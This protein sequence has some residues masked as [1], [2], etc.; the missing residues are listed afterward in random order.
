[1]KAIWKA[2]NNHKK[3]GVSRYLELEKKMERRERW[4]FFY[5]EN[6]AF[7][8]KHSQE[9]RCHNLDV[10]CLI[11]NNIHALWY[12]PSGT[13]YRSLKNMKF[14][15]YVRISK[16]YYDFWIPSN[17]VEVADLINCSVQHFM[18]STY[19]IFKKFSFSKIKLCL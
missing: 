16:L 1:M 7:H 5:S 19:S 3:T 12:H 10:H 6:P 15:P 18:G 9:F 17:H 11:T 14:M 8:I 4:N 13:F 2:H